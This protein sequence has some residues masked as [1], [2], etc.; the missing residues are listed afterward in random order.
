MATLINSLADFLMEK[1]FDHIIL[2]RTS[3][4]INSQFMKLLIVLILR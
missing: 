2:P 4:I 1:L 3:N